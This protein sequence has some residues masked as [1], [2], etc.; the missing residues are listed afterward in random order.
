MYPVG[1]TFLI[2]R[3]YGISPTDDTT[4]FYLTIGHRF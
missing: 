4:G 3:D 2:R 1:E